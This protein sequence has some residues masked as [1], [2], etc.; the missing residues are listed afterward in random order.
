PAVNS[1]RGLRSDRG[2]RCSRRP[3][4]LPT[5]RPRGRGISQTT[6][7]AFWCHSH[8]G[9]PLPALEVGFS[10][11]E[12]GLH[13]L[14]LVLAREAEREEVDLAVEALAQVRARGRLDGLLRSLKGDGA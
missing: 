2:A 12:E 1:S 8:E 3:Q 10:L 5:R 4:A 6:C 9:G 14:L 7:T 13:A 11:L